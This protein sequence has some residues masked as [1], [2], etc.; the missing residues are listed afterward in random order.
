M[1]DK[2]TISLFGILVVSL[3]LTGFIFTKIQ[4]LQLTTKEVQTQMASLREAVKPLL[5]QEIPATPATKTTDGAGRVQCAGDVWCGEKYCTC[6]SAGGIVFIFEKWPGKGSPAIPATPPK[7]LILFPDCFGQISCSE[8]Y[9]GCTSITGTLRSVFYLSRNLSRGSS[10]DDVRR[11]Q[12]FIKQLPG[13][14]PQGDVTGYYG[15][16]TESAIRR[17]EK[18]CNMTPSGA[19]APK[20]VVVLNEL[21][22]YGSI[23]ICGTLRVQAAG[24]SP[25]KT[26]IPEDYSSP[27]IPE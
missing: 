5:A 20:L 19:V 17:L 26:I 2:I 18:Q 25:L 23:E 21:V 11:L 24:K 14:Y 10:G 4:N 22:V 9:C 7:D 3:V 12:S 13:I 1:K 16:Q 27:G 15:P 8:S 6:S